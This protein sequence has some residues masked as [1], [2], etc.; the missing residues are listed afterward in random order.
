MW[1]GGWCLPP[2]NVI[3]TAKWSGPVWQW[4]W[5]GSTVLDETRFLPHCAV[6]SGLYPWFPMIPRWFSLFLWI[7][8]RK[9]KYCGRNII[10]HGSWVLM[11]TVLTFVSLCST[12][13]TRYPS[14]FLEYKLTQVN[15]VP[16]R[17]P[18]WIL[19]IYYDGFSL[20]IYWNATI[21]MCDNGMK[22]LSL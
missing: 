15:F 7:H 19:Y 14:W 5:G 2:H 12:E 10:E 20:Y 22:L 21:N 3:Q 18:W 6:I 8:D 1:A 13:I 4:C 16:H 11:Q 9:K 17:C